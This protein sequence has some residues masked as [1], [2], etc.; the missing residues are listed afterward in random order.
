MSDNQ[1]ENFHYGR[2]RRYGHYPYGYGYGSYVGYGGYAPYY[3]GYYA[4]PI[5]IKTESQPQPA[6]SSLTPTEKSF[7]IGGAVLL[8]IVLAAVVTGLVL[9]PHNKY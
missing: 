8:G 6:P 2:R 9:R 1:D 3:G 7:L 5:V 4:D